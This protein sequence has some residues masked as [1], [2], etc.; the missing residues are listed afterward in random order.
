[1]LGQLWRRLW[2]LVGRDRATRDLQEE[3][4][5]HRELRAEQL[6]AQG[7]PNPDAQARR[8]FG[9]APQIGRAS[10]RERV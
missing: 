7:V 10:C 9:N 2:L 5:L 8:Q 6:R 4:R 1:M 3:M